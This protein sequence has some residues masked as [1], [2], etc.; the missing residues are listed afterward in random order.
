MQRR[1]KEDSILMKKLLLDKWADFNDSVKKFEAQ[2]SSIENSFVFNFVEG[3]LVKAIRAGEWLLLDEVNLATADTLESISDLLTE[4]DSR[5]ILLSEKG[6]AEPIKAHPDF[7]IFACMNPATDVGKRDLPMGIRSRFTEIYVHSPE[8]DI[9]DLLSI[10]DK[11]I[12]KYSVS[13]EWVGNDIAELYLEAKNS[14]IT[15][16]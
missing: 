15:I 5:S 13:D 12:G 6:D 3:S 7:R 14:P 8:R 10:I 2:S 1:R 11:Y 16:L 9:T 4:P